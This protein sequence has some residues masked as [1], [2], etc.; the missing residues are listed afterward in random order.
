[1]QNRGA[2]VSLS[3]ALILWSLTFPLVRAMLREVPLEVILTL[4]FSLAALILI[5][6]WLWKG[7]ELPRGRDFWLTA[8]SGFCCVTAYQ[9]LSTHGVKTVSSGPASVL[10]EF[11]FGPTF[12]V[13][14]TAK[15]FYDTG[16]EIGR[17][18]CRER[19]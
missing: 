14:Q 9:L 4:R 18:S 15:G 1:M 2:L 10:V 17:A 19:V 12:R 7:K 16:Y 13:I 8:L 6:C 3:I 5:G 11:G